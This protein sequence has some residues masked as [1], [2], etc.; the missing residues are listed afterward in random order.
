[1]NTRG[2]R[3]IRGANEKRYFLLLLRGKDVSWSRFEERD[4]NV[5]HVSPVGYACRRIWEKICL[6]TLRRCEISLHY[7]IGVSSK[8]VWSV[9]MKPFRSNGNPSSRGDG[10]HDFPSRVWWN[11]RFLR[12]ETMIHACHVCTCV[13]VYLSKCQKKLEWTLYFNYVRICSF[14]RLYSW[15][16]HVFGRNNCLQL[17]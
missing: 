9:A 3:R 15:I 14:L 5:R 17:S 2:G 12:D 11:E 6:V 1:M 4:T 8:R 7:V 13:C 10:T 16:N